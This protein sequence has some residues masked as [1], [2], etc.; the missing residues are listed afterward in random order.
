MSSKDQTLSIAEIEYLLGTAIHQDWGDPSREKDLKMVLS[1]LEK[2]HIRNGWLWMR[3]IDLLEWGNP[4]RDEAIRVFMTIFDV[5]DGR[6]IR[7]QSNG[8]FLLKVMAGWPQRHPC[9]NHGDDHWVRAHRTLREK[10]V[11]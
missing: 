9:S 6:G 1:Q 11:L 5:E 2:Q 7:F 4:L 8:F 10:G 3:L